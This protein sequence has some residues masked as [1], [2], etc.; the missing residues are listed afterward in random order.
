MFSGQYGSGVSCK[1]DGGEWYKK[2]KG[3]TASMITTLFPSLLFL[4]FK[5]HTSKGATERNS[6]DNHFIFFL[7]PFQP[8]LLQVNS[9]TR[10]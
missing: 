3:W 7:L 1:C 10:S 2:K 5:M 6:L 4:C 9:R 8:D